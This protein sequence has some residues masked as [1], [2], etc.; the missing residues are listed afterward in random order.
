MQE[1]LSAIIDLGT[2]TFHLLIANQQKEILHEEKRPVRMGV[3]GINRGII[4]DDGIK[5]TVDCLI[6]FYQKCKELKVDSIRAF[7]TSALRNAQNSSLVLQQIKSSTGIDVQIISGEEEARLIYLGVRQAVKLG[8]GKNLIMDIGGGS[9]EFIIANE[10]EIFWKQSFEVGGQ[11]L[12]ERFQKH[13]PILKEEIDDLIQYLK[14]ELSLLLDQ[15]KIHYPTCIVGSSG[16]FETL[17]DM[18]CAR[19]DIP[20]PQLPESPLTIESVHLIHQQLISRNKEERIAIPGMMEWRAEMIV[21]TASLIKFL[22]DHHSFQE[23][24]VSRFSLKEGVL[25]GY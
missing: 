16:S 10:K 15:I 3:G 1:N 21:V 6:H 12:L 25:F 18:H 4:T 11:R 9:V 20:N 24:K 14:I 13:D 19:H 17:S 2:N 23:I 8:I 5:R 7:G 22:L